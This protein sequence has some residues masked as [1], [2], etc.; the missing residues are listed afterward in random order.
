MKEYLKKLPAEI[1]KLIR[2][3]KDIALAKQIRVYL[4]GGFVRDMLLGAGNL[5]L[6]IV[7]EGNGIIFA[8]DFARILKAKL[9]RHL[10]FGTATLVIPKSG[11]KIDIATARKETYPAPAHLPEVISGRLQDDLKRRDFTFNAMAVSINRDNFGELIDFFQGRKDLLEKK[12]RI[13]HNLSFIDDPTRI[14]RAIRFEQRFNF[15]MERNALARLKEAVQ[16]NMLKKVQ[17]QRL[18]DELILLLKEERPIKQIKRLQQLA[19]FGFIHPRLSLSGKG[20]NLLHLLENQIAWFKKQ[21]LRQRQ[22]DTWLVY[23]IGLID[24]LGAPAAKSI[25]RRFAFTK[26]ETK[27][28]LSS[29]RVTL[30]LIRQLS[31]KK[32]PPARIFALLEPLSDEAILLAKAKSYQTNAAKNIRD[33]LKVYSG[34]RIDVCGEDLRKLGITPGPDYRKILKKI[35]EAK[36]NAKVKTRE[37]E[38]ALIRKI[39]QAQ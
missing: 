22:I 32:I 24:S 3:A 17:P 12:I 14:L 8:E 5:D 7:V 1:K 25:C 11:L 28:I 26:E 33:F 2:L 13:L 35:L 36:L 30:A 37:E 21:G 18:R 23:F 6:D 34:M 27:S 4:V 29:Q 10:R 39:I 31:R 38:L 20:Y 16:G 15:R 9:T 19:G